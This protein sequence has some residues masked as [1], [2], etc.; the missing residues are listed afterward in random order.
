MELEFDPA[1]EFKI[2][3]TFEF[4]EEIQR[5]E[6]LRF[7]TLDEQL[8]D[9]IEKSLPEGKA[10]QFQLKELQ[11]KR[12]RLHQAYTNV[13]DPNFEVKPNRVQTIPSWIHPIHSE[14]ELKGYDYETQWNP[15]MEQKGANYYPR[16]ILALPKP[17]LTKND[18]NPPIT[19]STKTISRELVQTIALGNYERSKTVLHEDGNIEVLPLPIANTI[20]DI[21]IKGYA[22]DSRPEIP[23]PQA[24]HPFFSSG[25]PSQLITNE[26][27]LDVFPSIDAIMT[28]GVP[29]T[30]DPYTEGNKYLKLYD[31]LFSDISWDLW[32][33]R[34]PVVE[35]VEISPPALSIRFPKAETKPPSENLLKFYTPYFDGIDP[36]T[37]LANQEDGGAF[38]PR[39]W[40]SKASEAGVLSVNPIPE[41]PELQYPESTPEECLNTESFDSFISSGI[42][43]DGKCLPVSAV[44]H[45]RSQ[46]VSTGR[47][48]WHQSTEDDILKEYQ[49]LLRKSSKLALPAV[50]I[51]YKKHEALGI[52]ELRKDILLLLDDKK[53]LNI[54]KYSGILRLMEAIIPKDR[55]Y[56]D[57]KGA[58]LVCEHTIEL[59]E[60][61]EMEPFYREWTFIETGYRVCKFCG[62]QINRDVFM[63]Q[64]DFDQ[65]G[66]VI[67]SQEKLPT[68][69]FHGSEFAQS[70]SEL[71]EVFQLEKGVGRT[72]LYLLLSLFQVVP[73]ESQ[74]LPVLTFMDGISSAFKKAK[75][76]TEELEGSIGIM[77][78]G[79]LLQTHNPILIPRRSFGSKKLNLSGYPRD[80]EDTNDANVINSILRVL[81]NTF[82]TFPNTFSGSVAVFMRGLVNNRKSIR[83]NAISLL[84][85]SVSKFQVQFTEAKQRYESMPKDVQTDQI[86]MPL[87]VPKKETFG[88]DEFTQEESGMVCNTH[89]PLTY[90]VARLPPSIS[91]EPLHLNETIPSKNATL[92][93]AKPYELNLQTVPDKTIREKIK[94]GNPLKLAVLSNYIDSGDGIA[95]LS[96]LSRLIHIFKEKDVQV[97]SDF[98]IN[99]E[100]KGSRDTV[101]G[102][103]YDF[104]RDLKEQDQKILV[105]ALKEDTG[106]R[107]LMMNPKDA[108]KEDMGLRARERDTLKKRLRE[109]S[110][111]ERDLLKTLLD[112]GIAPYII[113]NDDRRMM[114]KESEDSFIIEEEDEHERMERIQGADLDED[115]ED[116]ENGM[117]GDRDAI[118][119]TQADEETY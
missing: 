22:L 1:S 13:I 115:V 57:P 68:T 100:T 47:K 25:Q 45:E 33:K 106:L 78:M 2:L 103:V 40:L 52:P 11:L 82:E 23:N 9:Y 8:L 44:G 66:H 109:K 14:F 43:R 4:Q 92:L 88:P 101:K 104:L 72:I 36:Y 32:R 59:L 16:M 110:D 118:Y 96:L 46:L 116:N 26:P 89:R 63:A 53:R 60:E 81:E 34:F 17:Y 41:L 15:I 84:G 49:S 55:L 30:T 108:E 76:S 75:K 35:T 91:Q 48:A 58:F 79:V 61:P 71:R 18:E 10:T 86:E 50:E 113:T 70:L 27:F 69:T 56:L 119:G 80:S 105:K 87:L 54:D 20:D 38:V 117:R 111:A 5:P 39:M 29:T 95:L 31:V 65:A 98:V 107:M 12:E 97:Y 37:W 90:L 83:S 19:E 77:G 64:D 21:R 73:L 94:K 112:I 24:E 28:H 67:K 3:E 93:K 62:E 102:V 6:S 85:K 114:A 74:L 42:Y 7:Y 51:K 99:L